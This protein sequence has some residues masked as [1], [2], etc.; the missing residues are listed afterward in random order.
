[1]KNVLPG[2]LLCLFFAS[3]LI[4][5]DIVSSVVR[6][7]DGSV[8]NQAGKASLT[9]RAVVLGDT[10]IPEPVSNDGDRESV[11]TGP[12]ILSDDIFLVY[13]PQTVALGGSVIEPMYRDDCQVDLSCTSVS[14]WCVNTASVHAYV[15]E[16]LIPLLEGTDAKE[17]AENRNGRFFY[18]SGDTGVDTGTL[19]DQIVE[20]LTRRV[21]VAWDSQERLLCEMAGEADQVSGEAAAAR[22]SSD[23]A[24]STIYVDVRERAGTDGSYAPFYL[25]IDDSQQHLYVWRD[26]V[27][28]HDYEV[29]GFFDEYAVFGVF[30]I[31]NKSPNAWSPIAEKWMP[32]WMAY[33]YDTR[34]SAW[35]GI[36]EL[37]YW[38]DENGV[39]HEESSAS[40]GNKKSGGC[41]RLDR[42]Q[43]EELYDIVAIG[44]PV[45]IHP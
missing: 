26:G 17:L 24:L 39:Y 44:T 33:H 6:R 25:E 19:V 15:E 43:A 10:S 29:S 9:D 37:V 30:S 32:F 13:G 28:T 36:H 23:P 8:E 40:I 27:V 22:I 12:E 14:T 18:R 3:G 20:L 41:I 42:G 35:L 34:Q 21:H 5:P 38:T 1:M 31:K 2:L 16:S 4:L 7:A 45:L 11:N